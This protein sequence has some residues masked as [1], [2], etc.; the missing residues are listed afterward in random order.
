[1]ETT[2][3]KMFF[4][5]KV[6]AANQAFDLKGQA[7]SQVTAYDP[8]NERENWES[9]TV[10]KDMDPDAMKTYINDRLALVES[11]G[12]AKMTVN[13]ASLGSY[14]Y[15]GNTEICYH[16]YGLKIGG[17]DWVIGA[18]GYFTPME[19]V[20]GHQTGQTT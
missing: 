14:C 8:G 19:I 12:G 17:S 1:M 20:F 18:T 7:R 16:R 9:M 3:G 10:P 5:Y 4:D 2:S 11:A 13:S 15:P 6:T